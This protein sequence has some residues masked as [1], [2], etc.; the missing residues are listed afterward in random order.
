MEDLWENARTFDSSSKPQKIHRFRD[1][2]A[3]EQSDD[4]E[5]EIAFEQSDE[6][7]NYQLVEQSDD[8]AES[9]QLVDPATAA[10]TPAGFAYGRGVLFLSSVVLI[11]VIVKN[12]FFKP[13]AKQAV[14][15][16]KENEIPQKEGEEK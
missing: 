12:F 9:Y 1:L 4:Y 8:K 5:A 14:V 10:P 6:R 16:R 11:S 15:D 2:F 7:E 3:F 13:K